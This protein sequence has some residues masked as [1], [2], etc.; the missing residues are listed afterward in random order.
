MVTLAEA[1]EK[2]TGYEV[3][4]VFGSTGKLYA[5]IRN[6][7]PYDAFFS[8]DVERPLLL[9]EEGRT[10][11][12]T[13]FTYAI[14]KVVLWSPDPDLV[15]ADGTVLHESAVNGN[16]FR[17]VALA[18]PILAPYGRAAEQVLRARGVWDAL[19]GRMVRGED[20]G[21]AFQYV[22]SGN[23]EL[24]FVSLAQL[25]D[26]A[27]PLSGVDAMGSHWEPPQALY[28]PIEQQAV[29][30]QENP[31]ARAFL[32]YVRSPAAQEI[33]HRYGYGTR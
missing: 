18:N 22:Y 12:G 30:L 27:G 19:Q 28:D 8:A 16:A 25:V 2:Q 4:P 17:F 29:L 11:P 7:A 26:P 10:V 15:D 33:I 31:V 6:G 20:I 5:Q 21:Q 13:R 23:A 14:G 1:F 32:D 24:G 9:Q 3:T